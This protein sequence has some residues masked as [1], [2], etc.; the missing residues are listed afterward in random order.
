MS[1]KALSLSG[2]ADELNMM[3]ME[4][5]AIMACSFQKAPDAVQG[6]QE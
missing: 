6:A 4:F 1:R 5:I 3:T 2:T